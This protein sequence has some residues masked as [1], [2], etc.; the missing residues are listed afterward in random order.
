MITLTEAKRMVARWDKGS[1]DT[2]EDNIRHHVSLRG[3]N[4]LWWY[5]AKAYNFNK[6]GASTKFLPKGRIHFE[7]KSGEFL[8]EKDGHIVTYGKNRP[9]Q[10]SR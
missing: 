10:P 7:R 9:K 5:L 4:D 2:R 3:R 6:K 8:I 1:F